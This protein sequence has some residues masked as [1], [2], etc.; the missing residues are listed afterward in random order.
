[1][2]NNRLYILEAFTCTKSKEVSLVGIPEQQGRHATGHSLIAFIDE[3]LA[4]VAVN[5]QGRRSVVSRQGAVDEVR[6]L[7]DEERKRANTGIKTPPQYV[8][9]SSNN[10]KQQMEKGVKQN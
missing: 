2:K 6:K 1:M 4:K 9:E 5:L 10:I 8:H 3:L 7:R